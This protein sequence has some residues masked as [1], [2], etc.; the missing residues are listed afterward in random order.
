MIDE[1]QDTNE[2]Q[3]RLIRLLVGSE[4]NICVVGDDDQSIYQWRGAN[5]ENILNF[6]K[7]FPEA[8]VILL[9]QNYRS[10]ANILKA[11]SAVV[12]RNPG[13]KDKKLWTKNDDGELIEL[14]SSHDE[15]AEARLITDTIHLLRSEMDIS[16]DEFAIFYRTN[17]QSRA[18]EDALRSEGFPYQVFGGLKFYDRKEVKDILAYFRAAMNP[19]D[20]V[21]FKR[22]VNTPPRGIGQTTLGRLDAAAINEGLPAPAMLDDIDS[23]P[24]LKPAAI[25]KLESF[26]EIIS[27]VRSVTTS[28]NASDAL[29][30]ALEITGYMDWLMEDR[31]SES[32]ARMDNLN[33][34]VNAAAEFE[35]RS[36]DGNMLAFLDQAALVTGA[37]IVGQGDGD[38]AVKMMTA[39]IS[40]GLEFDVV[41]VAGLEENLFPHARSRDD[42]DSMREERRLLYVAM[43][44]ARKRLFLSH[45]NNRRILGM[46]QSNRPSRFLQDLPAAAL[47]KSDH[48][49][50]GYGSGYKQGY[51]YPIRRKKAPHA[52]GAEPASPVSS[53]NFATHEGLEVGMKVRHPEF[54]LGVIQK[55]EGKGDKAKLMIYFPRMG[56]MKL[57]KKYAKLEIVDQP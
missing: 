53:A 43:T 16:L 57:M 29:T 21:S 51:D 39:H 36:G 25:K 54:H 31:N 23:I 15:S 26:R 32:L 6:E 34:L 11:A 17:S 33:E 18:I 45:A 27:E 10:T 5:I 3:Y 8:K 30:R 38:G 12:S 22:I 24:G 9:E 56:P 4:R 44:R 7:D 46:Y 49:D 48:A 13:R 1:F 41:F 37:D 50:D 28:M 20:A 40:K 42:E 14:R 55:I 47:A 2:V 19:M 35:E 52:G